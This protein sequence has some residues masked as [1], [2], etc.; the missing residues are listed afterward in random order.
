MDY[1]MRNR[2][3]YLDDLEYDI[4][5]VNIHKS[6]FSKRGTVDIVIGEMILVTGILFHDDWGYI[7][8]VFPHK[9]IDGK[10]YDIWGFLG[11]KFMKHL[12]HL[13]ERSYSEPLVCE[14]V[15]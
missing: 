13:I 10:W 9:K 11:A 8:T 1:E 5:I 3:G 2:P 6:K 12:N 14:Q 15:R 4:R 7:S